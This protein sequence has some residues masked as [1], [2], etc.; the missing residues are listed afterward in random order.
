VR[1]AAVVATRPD[2]RRGARIFKCMMAIRKS[3]LIDS[4]DEMSER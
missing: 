3:E 1:L 4:D 2:T